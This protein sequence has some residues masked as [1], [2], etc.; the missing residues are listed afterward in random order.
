MNYQNYS[1]QISEY[2]LKSEYISIAQNSYKMLFAPKKAISGMRIYAFIVNSRGA[3]ER[4]CRALCQYAVSAAFYDEKEKHLKTA[5]IPI[6]VGGGEVFSAFDSKAFKE[7]G[8]FVLP[9]AADLESGRFKA[10]DKLPLFG[11]GQFKTIS[12]FAKSVLHP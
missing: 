6:F 3:D 12:D 10:A 8:A 9:C 5:V 1:D 7:N 11:G 2:F 4:L